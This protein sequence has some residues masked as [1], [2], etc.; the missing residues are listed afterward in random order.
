MTTITL[1]PHV[2][3][4]NGTGLKRSLDA[5]A[6]LLDAKRVT[7]PNSSFTPP[8][9]FPSTTAR[10]D[11]RV[12][13]RVPVTRACFSR[14]LP[15]QVAFCNRHFGKYHPG[16]FPSGGLTPVASM[17]ELNDMLS[18][19]TNHIVLGAGANVRNTLFKSVNAHGMYFRTTV[20]NQIVNR[21]LSALVFN[22]SLLAD[23]HPLHQFAVDGLVATRVEEV[24][25]VNTY[26]S[27]A[28]QQACIVAAKGHAPMRLAHVP[29]EVGTGVRDAHQRSQD[30]ASNVYLQPVRI[31]AKIYV[32]LVGVL[33]D[34]TKQQWMLQ[35]ELVSSSNLEVDPRFATGHKLFR[36]K[37]SEAPNAT[38]K[39]ERLILR[40]VELGRVVDTR[41]GPAAQPQL[42]VCVHVVL[43][44]PTELVTRNQPDPNDSTK[45]I[46][47][48]LLVP[49]SVFRAFA[50]PANP[51]LAKAAIVRLRPSSGLRR[52]PSGARPATGAGAAELR[53]LQQAIADMN[54]TIQQLTAQVAANKQSNRDSIQTLRT[55]LQ[56]LLNRN[57]DTSK[58][59][60][61]YVQDLISG[62]ELSTREIADLKVDRRIFKFIDAL[63]QGQAVDPP[64][65]DLDKKLLE[66]A[67]EFVREYRLDDVPDEIPDEDDDV[68][69]P[70]T[71]PQTPP[72]PLGPPPGPAVAGEI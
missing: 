30:P 14:L 70:F 40:V 39:G 20:N 68:Y 24:D 42:T 46:P 19:E 32:V 53:A 69:V 35:Y 13:V 23:T 49:R 43:H 15:G 36:S 21:R 3:A 18:I 17:E 45:T 29:G 31:L 37:L 58:D 63:R 65:S 41:F 50:A 6:P 25:D 22:D 8:A 7:P 56:R 67:R 2:E 52:L 44:E 16:P 38:A 66:F 10:P 62:L 55:E 9:R 71:E 47:T 57:R 4:P 48:E 26:S 1:A 72:R 28:A 5:A 64:A 12:N 27:A 61:Q 59:V 60:Q 34:A 11:Q 33:V 54:T 51:K